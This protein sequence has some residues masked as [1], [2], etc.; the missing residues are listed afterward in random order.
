V[1]IRTA[2]VFIMNDNEIKYHNSVIRLASMLLREAAMEA[3][4]NRANRDVVDAYERDAEYIKQLTIAKN[5]TKRVC[6]CY[7]NETALTCPIHEEY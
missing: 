3:M 4:Q 2:E 1:Y 6:K 5:D 7:S